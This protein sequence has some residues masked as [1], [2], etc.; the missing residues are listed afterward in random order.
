MYGIKG[1]SPPK[2]DVDDV[3]KLKDSITHK[4]QVG[5]MVRVSLG[6]MRQGVARCISRGKDGMFV[7][8]EDGKRYSVLWEHVIGQDGKK[9]KPA[10]V[11]MTD[12]PL[13]KS[14]L[15]TTTGAG[16]RQPGRPLDKIVADL[17]KLR[18]AR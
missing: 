6:G 5:D 13:A 2:R 7:E 14:I 4:V 18:G 12:K 9:A 17:E 1:Y 15:A 11:V 3:A 8:D 16:C 10:M